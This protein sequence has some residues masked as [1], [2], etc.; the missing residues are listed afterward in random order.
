MSRSADTV[1]GLGE[2]MEEIIHLEFQ[3]AAA[4]WKHAD[5][6]A[7][8]ALIY[9][10]YHVPA[11]SIVLLLR[12]EAEHKNMTGRV[13]YAPRPEHGSMDFGFRV[14]RLWE[15]DAERLI[16][17]ELGV[18]PLAVCGRF[19]PGAAVED[20]VTAFA[21]RIVERVNKEASPDRAGK[22]ITTAL[23]LSG[24]RVQRNVA[25][26]IFNGI[27]AMQES[28]TYLMI[29]DEGKEE[30][31]REVVLFVGEK[32]LGRAPDAVQD[33]LKKITDLSRLKRMA[34][35]A[36]DAPSWQEIVETP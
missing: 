13:R 23:L 36:H 22:L 8:N 35:A 18:A 32:R 30:G 2:P 25:L 16:G 33:E 15:I 17:A 20:G 27:P 3:S 21:R 9:A 5:V 12:R 24:L 11:H 26:K 34:F 1:I 28:D 14:V 10:A 31:A 6:L 4:A 7:Y 29:L 19:P